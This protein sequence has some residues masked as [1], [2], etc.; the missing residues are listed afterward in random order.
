[1]STKSGK[2]SFK[3]KLQEAELSQ[4]TVPVCLRGDLWAK[5]EVLDTE[6]R[7]ILT[8]ADDDDR[9]VGNVPANAL[10]AKI[11]ALQAEMKENTEDFVF[12]AMHHQGFTDLQA[13]HPPRKDD[14]RDERVGYNRDAFAV[15]LLKASVISPEL[16]ADDWILLLGREPD[17]NT[18]GDKGVKGKISKRQF[19]ELTSAAWNA[20]TGEVSAPLSQA[21]LRVRNS[22]SESKRPND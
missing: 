2:K 8:A 3:D 12:E 6:L 4:R 9:L 7:E 1:M 17:P 18:P 22:G 19:D 15:A 10:A 20:N 11:E 14:V 21:A 5:I 16:D 13:A